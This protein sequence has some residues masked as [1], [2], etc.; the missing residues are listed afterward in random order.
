MVLI[1]K[2]SHKKTKHELKKQIQENKESFCNG[3]DIVIT[4][5]VFAGIAKTI[6]EN[7]PDP[8]K[9]A[10]L[11]PVL[12]LF[13][14]AAFLIPT[15]INMWKLDGA[16]NELKEITDSI[17]T[18]ARQKKKKPVKEMHDICDQPI[19]PITIQSCRI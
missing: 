16:K 13:S 6:V 15:G 10:T 7:T 1:D 2:S 8:S 9:L 18:K 19:Q 14:A 4:L 17:T 11:S 12:A 5:C 3:R